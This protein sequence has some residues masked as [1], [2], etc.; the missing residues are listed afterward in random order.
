[1]L[2]HPMPLLETPIGQVEVLEWGEGD[3]LVLLLHASAT[4]PA[5][6]SELAKNLMHPGRRIVAPALSGYGRTRITT[7]DDPI[8]QSCKL[9]DLVLQQ[10]R[11]GNWSVVG[12]SMGGL[13]TL[14][15]TLAADKA[16]ARMVLYEPI[17]FSIL[18]LNDPEDR[19]ARNF[20]TDVIARLHEQVGAGDP[21][22]GVRAFVEAWNEMDWEK[23][24]KAARQRLVASA[25][26]LVR[27]TAATGQRII[28]PEAVRRFQSPTLVLQ[29]EKSPMA[30]HRM[31]RRVSA[32]LPN[33][34]RVLVPDAGHM[35]PITSPD[36]ITAM[37]DTFLD[38]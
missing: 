4:G 16:P 7:S 5:S 14:L 30:T 12:H 2:R 29:G 27:E 37:I 15:S 6:L 25:D 31:T 19:V 38:D 21:E 8:S 34:D 35:T 22:G 32:L 36:R 18:D 10:Y 33:A 23:I 28:D 11:T 17:V 3:E 1:M 20:D 13:V 26:N 24:P 9:V